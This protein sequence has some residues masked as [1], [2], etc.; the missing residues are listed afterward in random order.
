MF[1]FRQILTLTVTIV[2]SVT[3]ISCGTATQLVYENSKYQRGTHLYSE[4]LSRD[5]EE[6][7]NFAFKEGIRIHGVTY[8][9]YES[10]REAYR[11]YRINYQQ[12]ILNPP[13]A[14]HQDQYNYMVDRRYYCLKNRGWYRVRI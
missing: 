3:C 12:G 1:D 8:Y 10:A 5:L 14:P 2:I 13:K 6:C 11:N 9:E 4:S 7:G